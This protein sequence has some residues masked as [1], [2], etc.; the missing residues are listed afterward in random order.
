MRIAVVGATGPTGVL[1]VEKLLARGHD[2]VAYVRRPEALV[3]RERLTVVGGEL[4]DRPAFADAIRGCESIVCTLGNR[5]MRV[6]NF[7]RVHL[8][9]VADAM[10][11]AGVPRLVLM[12]ALGGGE[13]PP[14]VTGINKMVFKWLSR[15]MFVDRTESEADLNRRGINWCGVYPGFLTD[16]PAVASPDV[17]VI[18][19]LVSFKNGS[20]P[21]ANVADVLVELAENPNSRGVRLAIGPAG[22]I[23]S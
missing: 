3:A 7:M 17:V 2:V 18:D 15:R 10:T 1:V 14:R 13:L 19:E 5:S 23:K 20:I 6:R 11:D 4:A 9:L 12:S 22:S 16:K 21:R 8:P